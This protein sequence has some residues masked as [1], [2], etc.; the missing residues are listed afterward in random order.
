M[1]TKNKIWKL[2]RDE[3]IISERS[4]KITL[5]AMEKIKEL[6]QHENQHRHPETDG[7]RNN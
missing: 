7:K 3:M 2:I 4:K 5:M 1:I 6:S